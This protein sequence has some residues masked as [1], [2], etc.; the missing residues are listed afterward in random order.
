MTTI[1]SVSAELVAA[2]RAHLGRWVEGCVVRV[3][4]ERRGPV[5]DDVAAAARQAARDAV[6]EVVPALEALL[7]RDI[8]EQPTN[9]LTLLRDAVRYPTGVLTAAGVPTVERDEFAARHFPADVYDLSP[10]AFADVSPELHEP[11]L[12]WGAAKA[13]VH[14]QRRRDRE[15]DAS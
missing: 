11:G 6:A 1:E 15:R 10:A 8:D 3:H 13:F 2:V 7:A 12:R 4:E 5:P 9:P 14:L